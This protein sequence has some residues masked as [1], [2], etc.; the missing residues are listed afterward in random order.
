MALEIAVAYNKRAAAVG[1]DTLETELGVSTINK[2]VTIYDFIL[3]CQ[4]GIESM[5]PRFADPDMVLTGLSEAPG[6]YAG[7]AGFVPDA[8]LTEFMTDA[9]LTTAGYWRRIA[10]GG[11]N[12]DPWTPYTGYS[13]GRIVWKD[14]AGPWLFKDL[15]VALTKMTRHIIVEG[16]LLEERDDTYS[17]LYGT[18]EVSSGPIPT[19]PPG[20]PQDYPS[21]SAGYFWARYALINRYDDRNGFRFFEL[22]GRPKT[23]TGLTSESKTAKLIVL[24]IAIGSTFYDWGYG[25]TEDETYEFAS[26][27]AT[28]DTSVSYAS[29]IDILTSFSTLYAGIG[30]GSQALQS[31]HL[32]YPVLVADYL[33]VD[34]T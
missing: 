32:S 18:G 4:T 6:S 25:W 7:A 13:Y 21:D 11:S 16:F 19:V 23:I 1:E 17:G 33:F 24:P 14:L 34:G 5:G 12:P 15:Q 3:T 10:A 27:P 22:A 20:V 29:S 26:Y 8:G 31:F 28:T 30:S 9:G 2:D